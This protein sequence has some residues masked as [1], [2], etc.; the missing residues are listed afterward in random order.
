M[1]P[2]L[3]DLPAPGDLLVG[4]SPAEPGHGGLSDQPPG[5]RHQV[6]PGNL[7]GDKQQ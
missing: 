2:N 6:Q 1:Y 5:G 7:S 4:L 3:A